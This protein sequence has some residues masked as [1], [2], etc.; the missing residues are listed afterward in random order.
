MSSIRDYIGIRIHIF[1]SLTGEKIVE[2]K[3]PEYKKTLFT[4]RDGHIWWKSGTDTWERTD[5]SL[6]QELD[7]YLFDNEY[8]FRIHQMVVAALNIKI[9]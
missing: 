5:F 7:K 4:V 2:L 1:R 3:E 9:R 6:D 8:D